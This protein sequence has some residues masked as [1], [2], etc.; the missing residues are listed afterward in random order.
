MANK[1]IEGVRSEKTNIEQSISFNPEN[2]VLA[3]YTTKESTSKGQK[4][5]F[6]NFNLGD[7]NCENLNIKVKGNVFSLEIPTKGKA[8]FI[9]VNE[10]GKAE[11]N[12]SD[13][14][15]LNTDLDKIK[16]WRE[17]FKLIST[18]AEEIYSRSVP[19]VENQENA[20][21]YFNKAFSSKISKN[22]DC[23]LE[24]KDDDKAKI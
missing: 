21:A 18:Q 6:Y 2:P 1:N 4:V 10:N 5:I 15:L 9:S 16:L 12:T 3:T 19:N 8:K 17:A 11:N 13:F 20:I 14:E 7:L 23:S 24:F 22:C